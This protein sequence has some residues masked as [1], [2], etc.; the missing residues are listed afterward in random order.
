MA[1]K[2]KLPRAPLPRQRGGPYKVRKGLP[3]RKRKHKGKDE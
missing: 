3:W 2:T 1:T